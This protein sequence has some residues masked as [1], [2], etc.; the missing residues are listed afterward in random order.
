MFVV[1]LPSE[2]N[3]EHIV[4]NKT[5]VQTLELL[6]YSG[7]H[8]DFRYH[9]GKLHPLVRKIIEQSTYTV[10]RIMPTTRAKNIAIPGTVIPKRIVGQI[11]CRQHDM[12]DSHVILPDG[13]VILCCMDYGMKHILGNILTDDYSSLNKGNELNNVI[14]GMKDETKEILCRYCEYSIPANGVSEYR[15]MN[16]SLRKYVLGFK[17]ILFNYFRPIYVYLREVKCQSLRSRKDGKYNSDRY[18]QF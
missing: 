12:Y 10:H 15:N 13:S 6:T 8:I 9:G 7:I 11:K 1:H 3:Y 5:Y 18:L 16:I 14:T 17:L 4:V 2:G